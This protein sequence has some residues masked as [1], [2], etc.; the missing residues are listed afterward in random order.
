MLLNPFMLL[1]TILLICSSIMVISSMSLFSM[2]MGLEINMIMMIPMMCGATANTSLQ[3]AMIYFSIQSISSSMILMN[4][5]MLEFKTLPLNL[6]SMLMSIPIM[7]KLAASPFHIWLPILMKKISWMNCFIISTWQKI[8]PFS[9]L[10]KFINNY[11]MVFAI[12]SLIIGGLSAIS[13][14][15]LKV[16]MAFS[17]ISNTGWLI[18]SVMYSQ[19]MWELFFIVYS[20]ITMSNMFVFNMMNLQTLHHLLILKMNKFWMMTVSINILS[21]GGMPP[22]LGFLPKLMIMIFN[23]NL[24]KLIMILALILSL[25]TLMFYMNII[26]NSFL[27]FS[28][29]NKSYMNYNLYMTPW[30]SLSLNV[31]MPMMILLT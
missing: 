23:L 7:I 3:A 28:Y 9:I 12:L 11:I 15:S 25:L 20:L 14:S 17:T 16:I 29:K 22:F 19:K 21:L 6:S 24:L 30:L 8:A 26:L 27:L 4:M 13:M 5:M 2:W 31:T 1:M 18:L 10:L